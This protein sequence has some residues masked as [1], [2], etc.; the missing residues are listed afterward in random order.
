MSS[1]STRISA[2]YFAGEAYD[3]ANLIRL[4][5]A[6]AAQKPNQ[7]AFTFLR[8]GEGE[9]SQLTYGEL[10]RRARAIGAWLQKLNLRGERVLLLYPPGLEY[11]TAFWGCLYAGAVAVP[12]YPPRLNRHQQRLEAVVADARAAAA[13][14]TGHVLARLKNLL[15]EAP[16]LRGLR[17]ISSEEIDIRAADEWREPDIDGSTLA[18]L[19]YTSGSTAAPKGVMVS[20]GNLLHNEALIRRAF[21]Q[22]PE[23]VIVG[24][25]PLYHDMG[26]IGNVLQP[27]YVGGRCV[28]MSPVAFLQKPSRWLQAIS[29][30]RATTSGGPNFAYD[31]CARKIGE[32]ERARL[33]LSSWSVAFNGAEP[34]RAAT[35]ERFAEAFASSGF[36]REAFYPCYGL[37]EATL[38][39][40]GKKAAG[41]P[42]VKA[43]EKNALESGR[44]REQG[45]A[46]EGGQVL[47]G[48]GG[49]ALDQKV[50]VVNTESLNVCAGD[51]VG[52]IWVR[53]PSVA[54]GYWNRDEETASTFGAYLADTGE[55]PFLR[56]GDLGFLHDGELFIT[57]RA[58]DLLIIRGR[59]LYPHD[60]ERTAEESHNALRPGGG[61]AF[62]VEA[63][64]EERLVVVHEVNHRA[65]GDYAE[66]FGSILQAVAE[67]HE[68]RPR[69]LVLVKA[70]GVPKT[71]SGKLQRG[72]ARQMFL[73][74]EFQALAE[75]RDDADTA[76]TVA[77]SSPEEAALRSV[78]E[79]AEFIRAELASKLGISAAL[80]DTTQP[81]TRYG[82]DSLMAV[83]LTHAVESRLGVNLPMVGF[84][85]DLS[86]RELAAQAHLQLRDEAP[87]LALTSDADGARADAL[88]YGQQALWFLHRMSPQSAVYNVAS[89]V[90]VLNELDA[91][92]MRRAFRALMERHPALRTTFP[93]D[94]DGP[95][96]LVHEELPLD[97]A[98][99]DASTWSEAS[100]HEWLGAEAHSPF[101]LD[102]GSL[103]R[104]RLLRR[105][106]GEG[107]V[108][109]MVAHHIVVDFW[110]LAILLKEVGALY[111]AERRGAAAEL[112]PV[113]ARYGDYVRWQMRMLEG[114]EGE[115]LWQYWQRQLGGALPA[116]N[117]PSER[118]RPPVQ[119][120][121][122]ASHAFRLDAE[123][124]RRLKSLARESNVTLYTL[125][126]AAFETL[127][128]RYTA[129]EDFAVGSPSAGRELKAFSDVVG[130][131][132]NP[133]VMRADMSGDPSFAELLGRTR[134]T[135]LEAYRHQ[136]Y[137]FALLV[138]RLQPE[139]DASRSPL[140]QAMFVL[141]QAHLLKEEG[142]AALALGEAGARVRLDDLTLESVALTQR[143]AQFDLRLSMTEAGDALPA[144]FEYN[145]D[146]FDAA[147]IE[148]MAGH[149]E[150][151]LR[152]VVA[153][154]HTRLSAL[155][156]LTAGEERRLLVEWNDTRVDYASDVPLHRLIEEQVARTPDAVAVVSENE[157]LTFRELN[158]RANKLAHHLRARGV[159]PES[160]VG[161]LMERSTG[162]VVSLL[163][164][165]KAGGAYVPL[166]PAYPP[167]RL[168]FMLE[169]ARLSVLLAQK[170]LLG[171]LPAHDAAVI[172]PD[173]EWDEIEREG[174][175][176]PSADV[177]GANLAYVI[178]TSGSTGRPK[179]AMNTHEGIVNRLLWMQAAYGLSASDCVLQKTP[180]SFDVSVW[181][182]FWPLMTGARLVMARPGGH[183]DA[184]YLAN[185]IAAERVTTLHF[186]P[187]MLNAFLSHA[188]AARLPSLR[189]V[190]CS[191]EALS[192][193]LK[194]HFFALLPE[195]EL[196]NLYGPT[197]A[198][199]DVTFWACE[200]DGGRRVVPIGR[201]IAN[202]EI[203]VLSPQLRPVPVGVAGELYIGGVG[204][205]RGYLDRPEMTAERFV[206][207]PFSHAPG[208]RLYRTGDLA[209]FLP[210]GEVEFL[211]RIDHQVKVR[212]FRIELGEIES[213]LAAHEAVR[214]SV[215]V[216]RED[217]PGDVRLVAYVVAGAE[218]ASLTSAWRR[219]LKERLPE[220]MIPSAFVALDELPLLPNGKVDRRALPAPH[221]ARPEL[222]ETFAAPRNQVEAMVTDI[223]AAV[224]GLERIGINDNF[225]DAG[226]H[227]LLATQVVS[228]LNEAFGVE[229]PLRSMFEAP[230]ASAL[231]VRLS[232][233][234]GG[235]AADTRPIER[236]ARDGGLPLSFVQQRLW[237]LDQLEPGNIAYNIPVAIRLA[238][239]LDVATLERSL[240]EIVNRHEALRTTFTTVDGQPVQ[241]INPAGAWRLPLVD[242]RE[243]AEDARET[244]ARRMVNEEAR[245]PFDLSAGPLL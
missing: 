17:W 231:A 228:R 177:R 110:S 1:T 126:L 191:G 152:G 94:G 107:D 23:S 3:F 20:H 57:G 40:S 181:E 82:A 158:R 35:L 16:A 5:Q 168:A 72:R 10:E 160:R 37:A 15:N 32:D 182:F 74:G 99:V 243:L 150:T 87:P 217:A 199:V 173:D 18:F 214:E 102:E 194:E 68:A 178:Y 122:G 106:G 185:V 53:G 165:L 95:V 101:K 139:R 174:D 137:P 189:R 157:Q 148:R 75:W 206:P 49:L 230:T 92:A 212:G 156:I 6:R 136:A 221:A 125:L 129:Q 179:G 236:V 192:Y 121:G 98:E 167:Q 104:V 70:G 120:Y 11:I 210:G 44:V 2:E 43:V 123:L 78:E 45:A 38:L 207:H 28:L 172:C 81:V 91:D 229:L 223:F 218:G 48:C 27:L 240:R 219:F 64:G 9:E 24:W 203:Y 34:V 238:G 39:V 79:I 151:L 162:L 80:I 112:A 4:L 216:A 188:D 130:Y 67:E 84:L 132:V 144:S 25:L 21:G 227:S 14:T 69:A 215:V 154:P 145:T 184:A 47:V 59:N 88:S 86:I 159:G 193:E 85:Q 135:V 161:V 202:T 52:E 111:E 19:Q 76:E 36:R 61:V 171:V 133:L 245:L 195:V 8:D 65:A 164:V 163:A 220:Y 114:P 124:T 77:H 33:D 51:E 204:L 55:G 187:S 197:E 46:D 239:G 103:L 73:S 169:D 241:V 96:R 105:P 97:F 201:P 149:F 200:R 31:L 26:L 71:S 54:R 109:L 13:L 196:H 205:G 176:N 209:R 175:A 208:A 235:A 127:L 119:T 56:T 90:R 113:R 153:D 198:A 7:T 213:A 138:Q 50:V 30:Y 226:G 117:L 42:V 244:E 225:F 58:K 66:V 166:D 143:V 22:G 89:A 186:V 128:Y 170:S 242:L 180:F 142:I 134:R 211:G 29:D 115:R 12:A 237:F 116:L 118:P 83:E 233:E 155:P 62:S 190:I 131:F 232:A 222:E 146:L 147:T 60:I 141:Q 100:A 93:A 224:L 183:Q 140:F 63:D 234:T 41:P 108:L